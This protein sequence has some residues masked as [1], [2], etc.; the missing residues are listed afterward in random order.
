MPTLYSITCDFLK[1]PKKIE[2]FL[3]AIKS[4]KENSEKAKTSIFVKAAIISLHSLLL[5]II[6][7]E[8]E[9]AVARAKIT[10]LL[11]DEEFRRGASVIEFSKGA[12]FDRKLVVKNGK[13]LRRFFEKKQEFKE[14]KRYTIDSVKEV[15]KSRESGTFVIGEI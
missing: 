9:P 7:R 11:Q 5:E 2:E 4:L 6:Q 14:L 12:S 1:N 8:R 15:P 13:L 10:E 3:L